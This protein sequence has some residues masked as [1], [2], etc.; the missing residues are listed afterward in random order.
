M[1]ECRLPINGGLLTDETKF[2]IFLIDPDDPCIDINFEKDGIEIFLYLDALPVN[3]TQEEKVIFID[4]V[5][6]IL[7]FKMLK[8]PKLE[9]EGVQRIMVKFDPDDLENQ[10]NDKRKYLI[11]KSVIK[12]LSDFISLKINEVKKK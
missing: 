1:S 12:A 4:A 8:S 10:L 3:F 5:T 9:F 6:D 7:K 2:V 11:G